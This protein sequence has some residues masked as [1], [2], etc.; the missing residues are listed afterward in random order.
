MELYELKEMEEEE[1]ISREDLEL[2]EK[3][4]TDIIDIQTERLEELNNAELREV[5]NAFKED[6][7][8]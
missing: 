5:L 3:L 6:D 1:K 4:I 7:N 8:L 2:R